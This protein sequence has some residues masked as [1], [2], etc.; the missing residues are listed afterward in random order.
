MI[1]LVETTV[2]VVNGVSDL[3]EVPET[4]S[5]TDENED[6]QCIVCNQRLPTRDIL[7]DHILQHVQQPRILLERVQVPQS[8]PSPLNSPSPPAA[9]TEQ[10]RSFARKHIR[11]YKNLQCQVIPPE[12]SDETSDYPTVPK[13]RILL[14][15]Q[16]SDQVDAKS[17]ASDNDHSSSKNID[18][19][20]PNTDM[21]ELQTLPNES[22]SPNFP[23]QSPDQHAP[24]LQQDETASFWNPEGSPPPTQMERESGEKEAERHD[25]L[26]Q[27]FLNESADSLINTKDPGMIIPS[28]ETEFISLEKLAGPQCS[29][30]SERFVDQSSYDLHCKQTG[31]YSNTIVP[32]GRS[33]NVMPSPHSSLSN[34]LDSLAALP[35]QQLAQQVNRLQQGGVHQQ[36][37]LINIQQFGQPMAPSH[38]QWGPGPGPPEM[39]P[40]MHHMPHYGQQQ[41]PP[42][43]MHHNMYMPPHSQWGPAPAPHHPMHPHNMYYGPGPAPGPPPSSMYGPPPHV[44]HPP[45]PPGPSPPQQPPPQSRQSPN[46]GSMMPPRMPPPRLSNQQM[47]AQQ[48][49]RPVPPSNG[50]RAAVTRPPPRMNGPRAPGPP[51]ARPMN[52]QQRAMLA[53]RPAAL[54]EHQIKKKRLDVLIP[55][56]NDNE[57]CHVISMQKCNDGLPIIKNV[58]GAA[59]TEVD[60]ID[61]VV[62]LTDSITLSVRNPKE[63]PPVIQQKKNDAKAV[64]NILAT[65]GITVTP[66]TKTQKESVTP[67][68]AKPPA[69]VAINLNSAVSIIP[70]ARNQQG[71]K[72]G[73]STAAASE[74]PTKTPTVDLTDD[75]PVTNTTKGQS[76]NKRAL[77]YQCDL[78]PAQYPSMRTLVI[79]RRQYHK[80]GPQNELGVPVVD[81]SQQAVLARLAGLGIHSYIP[82]PHAD[83]S[84]NGTYALPIISVNA[85]RN[86]GVCNISALGSSSVLTLGPLHHINNLPVNK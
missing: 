57:D 55:D 80:A 35:M 64:A 27:N 30:C 72:N 42:H 19:N 38:S 3:D 74:K 48:G 82:L 73:N 15:Q 60:G 40:H 28:N 14:P 71:N 8:P 36:N 26:L 17:R 24:T 5:E 18:N 33:P 76:G 78:C 69:P 34:P 79:H 31:H 86:P 81:L 21:V 44:Q 20:S 9:P 47:R 10:R 65:R 39:P 84:G 75:E 1:F 61:P 62:H 83:G 59:T 49:A 22:Q 13:I 68:P 70:T 41:Q 45:R 54:H 29:V 2:A 25:S 50:T 32:Y 4:P 43:P 67:P 56:T 77:P 23:G 66:A 52:P 51:S 11:P 6:L 53:K 16:L 58:Q 46:S 12:N 63:A 37:V 85:A 7:N